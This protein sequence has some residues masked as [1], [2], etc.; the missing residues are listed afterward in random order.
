[1]RQAR[2]TGVAHAALGAVL[3]PG[4]CAVDATVGNGHDALFMARCVGPG[5][6]VIGFDVQ[7]AAL[8]ATRQAARDAGLAGLLE[9]HLCGHEAMARVIEP[10][11][12]G[13]VAA[14]TFNLG[15]LPGGDKSILT[16]PDTTT[17]ALQ[18]A[19]A[20][21]RPGGLI[22]LLVYRGH[23]GAAAEVAAVDAWLGGLGPGWQVARHDS[24]GPVL[25]LI[26]RPA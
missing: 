1:M 9:L 14:V 22:S 21:L 11:L 26:D 17:A 3:R 18:Q 20:L 16:R 23:P 24:P 7:E 19:A 15:Y 5:G 13:T 8:A 6:R 4:D 25:H 2:L 10:A 12:A